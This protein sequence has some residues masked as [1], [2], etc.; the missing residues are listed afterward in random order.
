MFLCPHVPLTAGGMP[1]SSLPLGLCTG[2]SLCLDH[3]LSL[4]PRSL[5]NVA[6]SESPSL[7]LISDCSPPPQGPSVC[8]ATL[9]SPSEITFFHSHVSLPITVWVPWKQGPGSEMLAGVGGGMGAHLD[10]LQWMGCPCSAAVGAGAKSHLHF[11][12]DALG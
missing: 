1:G 10:P 4:S 8:Q 12:G 7:T 5:F 2:C 9:G 6:F 11:L 3:C